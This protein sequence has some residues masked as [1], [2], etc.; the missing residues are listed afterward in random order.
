ALVPGTAMPAMPMS[1]QEAR[2]VTA[3]LL[4]LNSR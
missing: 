3:Y 2:D 1:D 4:Q